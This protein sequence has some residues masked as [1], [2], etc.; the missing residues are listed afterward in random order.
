MCFV[1]ICCGAVM[2]CA[3]PASSTEEDIGL[4]TLRNNC[5]FFP[6]VLGVEKYTRRIPM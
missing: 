5:I 4:F 1:L 2:F 6:R 3:V